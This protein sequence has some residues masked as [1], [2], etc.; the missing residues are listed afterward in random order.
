M[1]LPEIVQTEMAKA[2]EKHPY[3]PGDLVYS[4]GIVVEE[5]GEL[6][7]AALRHWKEGGS[8][9][10][11]RLEAAQTAVTAL[12]LLELLDNPADIH[13]LQGIQTIRTTGCDCDLTWGVVEPGVIE[14]SPC[15]CIARLPEDEDD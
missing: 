15:P 13:H 4:A 2:K 14:V 9:E 11:V 5:A 8:L 1:T 7:R 3:W 6:M 12:R 10:D